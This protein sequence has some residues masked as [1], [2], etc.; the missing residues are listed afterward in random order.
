[1]QQFFEQYS[2]LALPFLVLYVMVLI[3]KVGDFLK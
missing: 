3:S 1:M 2:L